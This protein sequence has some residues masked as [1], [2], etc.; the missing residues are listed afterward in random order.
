VL[1]A[2][3]DAA[4]AATALKAAAEHLSHTVDEAQWQ[5]VVVEKLLHEPHPR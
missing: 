2:R 3:G 5:R 4:A 1:Q